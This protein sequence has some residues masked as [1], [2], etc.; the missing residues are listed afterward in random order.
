MEPM[1]E[2]LCTLRVEVDD[3]LNDMLELITFWVAVMTIDISMRQ[4]CTTLGLYE[5]HEM[6]DPAYDRLTYSLASFPYVSL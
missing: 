6:E 1:L 3:L 4:F 5:K 2:F